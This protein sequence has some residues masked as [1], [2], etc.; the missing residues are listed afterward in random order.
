MLPT[1]PLVKATAE[2]G[3]GGQGETSIWALA[4]PRRT[5]RSS[6]SLDDFPVIDLLHFALIWVLSLVISNVAVLFNAYFLLTFPLTTLTAMIAFRYLGLSLPAAAVG[7]LLYSFLPFH[8]QR[9]GESLFPRGVLDGAAV[10][11]ADLRDLP[12][13]FA[14]LRPSRRMAV[15]AV[16][17]SVGARSVMEYSGS[18]SRRRERTTRS[19]PVR[20]S[21]SRASMA[22]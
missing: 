13:R 5:G 18:R 3:P 1:V 9:L 2:R 4:S 12:G 21:P 8:Y 20:S 14:F 11:P 10:F 22:G 17:S 6:R 19:S 7:G 15:I 16:G